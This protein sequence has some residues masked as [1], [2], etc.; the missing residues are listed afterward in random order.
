VDGAVETGEKP[1]GP[2]LQGFQQAKL[3]GTAGKKKN[4]AKTQIC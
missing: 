3:R 4:F 1:E 2:D